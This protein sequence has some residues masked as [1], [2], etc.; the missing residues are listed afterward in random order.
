M[1][2]NFKFQTTA[3]LLLIN[4]I[5]LCMVYLFWLN[6]WVSLAISA[7]PTYIIFVITGI[8]V[9]GL[10]LSFKR[11]YQLDHEIDNLDQTK[12]DLGNHTQESLTMR[13]GNRLQFIQFLSSSAVMLGLIGTIIG[14]IIGL[15]GIDPNM[16]V[17]LDTMVQSVVQILAGMSVAFYTT[18]VGCLVN[19]WLDF[20]IVVI[21]QGLTRLFY[22][23]V[24]KE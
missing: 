24:G 2:Q 8:L 20:N 23:L 18:L 4:T 12:A 1:K 3:Q 10:Y 14:F 22:R 6:S 11:S 13:F 19:I 9:W 16:I 17:N 7:D 21:N 15:Y 5:A